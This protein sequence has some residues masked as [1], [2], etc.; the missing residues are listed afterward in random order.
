VVV[1]VAQLAGA[2]AGVAGVQTDDFAP[3]FRVEQVPI[4]FELGRFDQ[5]GVVG[6]GEARNAAFIDEDK[7]ALGVDVEM[8]ALPPKRRVEYLRQDQLRR[9]RIE[10][11][12][13]VKAVKRRRAAEIDV[14]Q[15][16]P[17]R[18]SASR[19]GEMRLLLPWARVTLISG[20]AT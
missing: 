9:E 17:A 4:R 2:E 10:E 13:F 12:V 3:P 7:F 5:L 11:L 8:F 6:N 20:K 18:R 16:L 14:G 1:N 19:R 15:V